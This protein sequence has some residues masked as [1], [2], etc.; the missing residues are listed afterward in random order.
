MEIFRVATKSSTRRIPPRVT[1]R[2]LLIASLLSRA[3]IIILSNWVVKCDEYWSRWNRVQW[4]NTVWR[5]QQLRAVQGIGRSLLFWRHPRAF[6][7]TRGWQSVFTLALIY[8]INPLPPR[9]PTLTHTQLMLLFLFWK[10][11]VLRWITIHAESKTRGDLNT[12]YENESIMNELWSVCFVAWMK[13]LCKDRNESRWINITWMYLL[14]KQGV[15]V[16]V[17]TVIT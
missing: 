5:I 1:R 17:N 15:G 9:P 12:L 8:P 11:L 7:C 3:W 2:A 6:G 14:F 10:M 13:A 4:A 16:L